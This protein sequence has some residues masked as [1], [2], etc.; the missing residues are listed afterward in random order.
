M[1]LTCAKINK[2]Q[3]LKKKSTKKMADTKLLPKIFNKQTQNADVA[4]WMAQRKEKL[5]VIFI[6]VLL[7]FMQFNNQQAANPHSAP[8]LSLPIRDGAC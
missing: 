8:G 3:V 6:V 2:I 7:I 1:S 5:D 4:A